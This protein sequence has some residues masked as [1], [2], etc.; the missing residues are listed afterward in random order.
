MKP[1]HLCAAALLALSLGACQ[2]TDLASA[3][4]ADTASVTASTGFDPLAAPR[5]RPGDDEL[6]TG[7]EQFRNGNF[8]LAEKHF[9]QAAEQS[10]SSLEA[11]IGLAASYDQLGRFD[12]ADRAYKEAF[13]IGGMSSVL[14]NNR[15]Y[16]YFLRR[17][18]RKARADFTEALRRDPQNATAKRNMALVNGRT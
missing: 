9:R 7:K 6:A 2:S 18:F 4:K 1:I 13:R 11:L 14:L 5:P 10:P 16:S 15:G 8:G 12:L 3:V 17:D